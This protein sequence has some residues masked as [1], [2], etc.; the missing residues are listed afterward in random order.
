[1]T[2]KIVQWYTGALACQQ[3]RLI[4]AHPELELVGAVVFHEEKDGRDA[5]ELAGIAPLGITATADRQAALHLEADCVLYNAPYEHYD[6]IVPLL[7]GGS[8]VISPVAGFY[9]KIRP[10]YDEIVS[11]CTQGGSTLAGSG[12]HPGFQGDYLPLLATSMCSKIDHV[13]IREW[14]DISDYNPFTLTE[15]MGFGKPLADLE[16]DTGYL[17]YMTGAYQEMAALVADGVGLP[18]DRFE[19]EFEFAPAT[20][21]CVGG[22]VKGGT[23]AAIRMRHIATGQRGPVVTE[24]IVWYVDPNIGGE[25]VR[26]ANDPD[27]V[28]SVTGTPDCTVSASLTSG[29]GKLHAGVDAGAARAINAIPM[30]CNAAPGILTALESPLPRHWPT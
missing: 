6:E 4:A 15:V 9:P 24:D 8:N 10:E 21:D 28:V 25:W 11:A 29:E 27:F 12:V 26:A 30:V 14:A 5:G 2:Y 7:A 22:A 20:G 16:R 18:W 19:A 23:M 1:M 3:I 17:S 13:H